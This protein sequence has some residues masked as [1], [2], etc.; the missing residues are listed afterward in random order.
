MTSTTFRV[1]EAHWHELAATGY[2]GLILLLVTSFTGDVEDDGDDDDVMILMMVVLLLLVTSFTG[3]VED[4]GDDMM[5]IRVMVLI[6]LLVTSF[7]ILQL[8]FQLDNSHD[9]DLSL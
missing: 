1:M 5:M 4:D 2:I 7:T 9:N 3:D 6:F 8:F